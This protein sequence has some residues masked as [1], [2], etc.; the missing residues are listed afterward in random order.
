MR[1]FTRTPESMGICR[2]C[3]KTAADPY[4]KTCPV[5]KKRFETRDFY[6]TYCSVQCRDIKEA[7]LV[8]RARQ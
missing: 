3:G 4:E 1:F 6:A 2:H 7:D 5:C 8:E